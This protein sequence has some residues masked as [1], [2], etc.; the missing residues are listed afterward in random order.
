MKKKCWLCPAQAKA[1][2]S[3]RPYGTWSDVGLHGTE[4]ITCPSLS[5][6]FGLMFLLI[7]GPGLSAWVGATGCSRCRT[8]LSVL[9][10]LSLVLFRV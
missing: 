7:P 4:L 6:F 8:R 10:G 2:R 9:A 1:E 3:P 5:P